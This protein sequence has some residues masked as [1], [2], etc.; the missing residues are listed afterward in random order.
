[1]R[2]TIDRSALGLGAAACSDVREQ[3]EP[4][5]LV[6]GEAPPSADATAMTSTNPLIPT[7]RRLFDR[8]AARG[9][10]LSRQPVDQVT[11][12][13]IERTPGG[14]IVRATGLAADRR[15]CRA[16]CRR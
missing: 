16:N 12:L 14:V 8:S 13:A 5:Q 3:P 7:E 15:F 6:G 2:I 9:D 10:R 11:D 4:V 1:M